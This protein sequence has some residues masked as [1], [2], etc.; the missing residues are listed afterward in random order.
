[1]ITAFIVPLSYAQSV[2]VYNENISLYLIGNSAL[3]RFNFTGT[4]I[5]FNGIKTV[6]SSFPDVSY[7]KL[8]IGRFN[9][10]PTQYIYFSNLGYNLTLS[11]YVSSDSAFL[12]VKADSFNSASQF[13]SALGNFTGLSFSPYGTFG[14]TYVFAAPSNFDE[15]INSFIWSMYPQSYGGFSSLVTLSELESRAISQFSLIGRNSGGG[16]E[17]S[18]IVDFIDAPISIGNTVSI[19]AT[20]FGQQKVDASNQSDLSSFKLITYGQIIISSDVGTINRNFQLKTSELSI[21]VPV[22]GSLSFPNVTLS[23]GTPSLISYREI[24]QGTLNVNEEMEVQLNIANIGTSTASNISYNDDWWS[25]DGIFTL[26]AGNSSGKIDSLAPGGNRTIVYRI[27]LTSSSAE[28]YYVPPSSVIYY[29][30]VGGETMQ[31]L[32]STNDLYLTLNENGPSVYVTAQTS[33]ALTS[34]GTPNQVTVRVSNEGKFAAFNLTYGGQ[35]LSLLPEGESSQVIIQSSLSNI[36]SPNSENSYICSWSDGSQKR[37]STSNN[38]T[39][40]NSFNTMNIPLINLTKEVDQLTVGEKIFLNFSISA[41]NLGVAKASNVTITDSLPSGLN[42]INGSFSEKNGVLTKLVKSINS[43]ETMNYTYLCEVENLGRNYVLPPASS[44]YQVGGI[45]FTAVSTSDGV[46]L[47]LSISLN[48]ADRAAFATYNTTGYYIVN[49]NGDQDV[50]RLETQLNTGSNFTVTSSNFTTALMRAGSQE[51][52]DFNLKFNGVGTNDISSNATFF[53][54]GRSMNVS[55]QTIL[56]TSYPPPQVTLNQ[57]GA[58]EEGKSIK[59]EVTTNNVANVTVNNISYKVLLP[60][61]FKIINGSDTV[62]ISALEGEKQESS[63]LYISSSSPR[64]YQINTTKIYYSFKGETMS[65]PPT[66]QSLTVSENLTA[67]YLIP[68]AIGIIVMIGCAIVL[69]RIRR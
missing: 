42:F 8:F 41:Q 65:S 64:D 49:N 43:S 58:T 61:Q 39:L 57:V 30:N 24:S 62:Q 20:F 17:R 44:F 26:T 15:V 34:F 50:F 63:T 67:R 5:G 2:N 56:V 47:A 10:W 4:G 33:T 60:S 51:K 69:G 31:L 53:F 27:K 45:T 11:E 21:S 35:F 48:L 55:S 36:S 6:E 19:G 25:K 32:S 23:S 3:T 14:G 16:F 18:V 54:A 28:E 59:I 66:S 37:S 52:I 40:I 22:E 68:I 7:Y 29:W 12:Y 38:L 46:P 13:A 1:M 9:S